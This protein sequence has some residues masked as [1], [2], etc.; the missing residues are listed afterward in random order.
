MVRRLVRLG[1]S[2]VAFDAN[3]DARRALAEEGIQVADSLE[4]M[5]ELL[6]RPR[7]VWMMVPAGVTPSLAEQLAA[8]LAPG[9]VL[10]DG[11]NSHYRAAVDRAELLNERGIFHLDVG[12]SGGV[13]GR[14]R[15]YCLMV[16]GQEQAVSQVQPYLEA[17]APGRDA[18]PPTPGYQGESSADQGYL[19]CGKPGAGHF[20]KMVHNAIEYGM[21]AAYAEGFNLLKQA[22]VG[23]EQVAQ[24]A[25]THPLHD[26]KY[27]RYDFKIDQVAEL[28]RR[29]S[30]IPSWLL[31][32]TSE[33]LAQ[34]ASL[35]SFSDRVSDSGEG[36]WA[37]QAAVDEGVPVHVL[38]A[39]L[40][41]RF[42]SRSHAEFSNR[43][44]SAM[45]FGF[46]G[47]QAHPSS[48]VKK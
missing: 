44:L 48:G 28:W 33:A 25:E 21:M 19:H 13:H 34:D 11:G 24:D 43:V 9:D 1:H 41:D 14:E 45:R 23:H 47:H 5:V 4:H 32:L 29:G 2:C 20:V 37:I 35:S 12:T 31:D 3:E 22:G 39:A 18:A 17:L 16:G 15:G 10:I 27:Y 42:A 36:R 6:E 46:G 26:S 30:V 8:L 40:F 38:S 7:A